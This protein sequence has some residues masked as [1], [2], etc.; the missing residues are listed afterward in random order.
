MHGTI[1]SA[2]RSFA[3]KEFGSGTWAAM[4][5]QAALGDQVYLHV[6]DYPDAEAMALVLAA[7]SLTGKPVAALLED[8]G[9]FIVPELMKMN[10]HLL[11]PQ[12]K[13]LDVIEHTE[14]TIHKVIRVK[15]PGATPPELKTTRLS[16]YELLLIYTSPRR[17]CAFAIGIGRGLAHRFQENI[18]ITQPVCMH[19]GT[20]HCEILFRKIQ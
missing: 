5:K 6:Q 12:W 3:E 8:F 9:E 2:L 19:Q 17:M 16:S 10:G 20:S 15:N 7:S 14:A 4:L 1:F 18:V 11:L 13:T